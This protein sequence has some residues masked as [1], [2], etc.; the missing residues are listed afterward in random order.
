[1]LTNSVHKQIKCLATSDGT[2]EQFTALNKKN[3]L[4]VTGTI[5]SWLRDASLNTS[6]ELLLKLEKSQRCATKCILNLP[7]ISSVSF[8]SRLQTLHLQP[9]CYWHEYLDM[10]NFF[11]VIH[12]I[13]NSSFA[14]HAKTTRHT[15][16]ST[17]T[18]GVKYK[19][20]K[21]TTYQKSFWIRTIR[22]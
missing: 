18:K 21:T 11:K 5:T 20:C 22:T 3:H 6:I 10:I 2:H 4:L 12:G 8:K 9:I 7:F 14:L 15:R 16:S 1:M 13:T 17:N 19:R